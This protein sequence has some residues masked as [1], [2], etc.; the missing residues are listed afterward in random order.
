MHCL[1]LSGHIKWSSFTLDHSSRMASKTSWPTHRTSSTRSEVRWS[2]TTPSSARRKN[3]RNRTQ[4]LTSPKNSSA[5]KTMLFTSMSAAAA[6]PR[7]R[8]AWN[9]TRTCLSSHSMPTRFSCVASENRAARG[10]SEPVKQRWVNR[11][12]TRLCKAWP[13]KSAERLKRVMHESVVSDLMQVCRLF[14]FYKLSPARH[15]VM[16]D[17][18]ARSRDRERRLS[19]PTYCNFTNFRWVKISVA[20]DRGAFGAV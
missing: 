18:D 15:W 2:W 9:F 19:F 7:T 11:D 10:R 14:S 8:S 6:R 16:R 5:L 12:K 1:M 20:S 17:R 13:A 3:G 4:A